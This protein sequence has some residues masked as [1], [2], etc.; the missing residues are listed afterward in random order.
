MALEKVTGGV[1]GAPIR[2][3]YALLTDTDGVPYAASGGGGGGGDASAANQVTGNALLTDIKGELAGT[4]TITGALTDTQLRATAVPVS[5]TFFQA[6]QPVSIAGTV[7]V[8]GPLT[9]T[10]LRATAVPVSGT[11]F[12][13]TQPVSGTFFQATQPVSAASLPLP[14]GASTAANQTTANSSLSSIDGKLLTNPATTSGTVVQQQNAVILTGPAAQSTVATDALTGNATS[15][16]SSWTDVSGKRTAFIQL[17]GSAGI[18]SG[19]VIFE[20]TNDTTNAVAGTPTLYTKANPSFGNDLP[21]IAAVSIAASTMNTYIVPITGKYIRVRINTAFVSGTIQAVALFSP[22][23][24][25]PLTNYVLN[26]GTA[27]S[28]VPLTITGN[29]TQSAAAS[30]SSAAGIL[31]GGAVLTADDTTLVANDFATL[32]FTTAGQ[33]VQKPY[34]TRENDWTYAAATGGIS[35]TTTAV[36]IKAAGAANIRN[37]ITG[38]QL[39]ADTL[40]AVTEVAIRDGAGGTVLWRKKIQTGG[41]SDGS[42][43]FTTPLQG[44]VATLMEVVTLSAT[45]TGGVFVNVQGYQGF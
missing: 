21:S 2:P 26:T 25:V 8:S 34:G 22:D 11:F 7:T 13:A 17:I 4:L 5:G 33:L 10:Q 38:I 36:T 27:V 35:N 41:L 12:Q 24:F 39:D 14:T 45:V 31:A 6:T 1:G 28:I 15:G 20:V 9:D 44:S 19:S 16:A 3:I 23:P 40:G 32:K 29:R 30:T 18:A 42:Y 43:T 37:F